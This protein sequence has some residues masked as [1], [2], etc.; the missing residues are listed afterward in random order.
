MEI[1]ISNDWLPVYKA[2]ASPVRL[3]IIQLLAKKAQSISAL[4]AQL[5]ISETITA[6]HLNQLDKTGIISFSRQGHFKIAKL[7]VDQI[8][9]KFPNT[10]YPSYNAYTV[11]IP[12][13]HYTN[14]SVAPSCGLAGRDGY[15][16]RVDHPSYFMDPQRI[17]AGMIWWNNGFVEYQ[18]PNHLN[19]HD[20]LRMIDITAELGSEFPFSNNNWPSDITVSL[21][22]VP[23]GY[24]TSPGDFSDVHGKYTPAWVPRNVNQYGLQ[25]V[26]RITDHGSYLDGEPWSKVSL[27]DLPYQNDRFTLRFEIQNFATHK[28][29]CTIF[30]KGFGNYNQDIEV[31]VYS[32]D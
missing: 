13:G 7:N 9:I 15:I 12:V 25:K 23:L 18:F 3:Q 27:S 5:G 24:W 19:S 26:F 28:G 30:G 20:Q 4:A 22:G 11:K 14:F 31:K 2:L 1:T 10:I 17:F 6:K 29:G 8:N 16:G 21:N 32:A